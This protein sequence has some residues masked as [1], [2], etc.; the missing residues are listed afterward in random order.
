MQWTRMQNQTATDPAAQK[1]LFPTMDSLQDVID[2]AKSKF[3]LEQ[4]N[5]VLSLLMCYHNTLLHIV[6]CREKS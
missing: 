4:H 3:P 5:D 2:L 1:P 6:K